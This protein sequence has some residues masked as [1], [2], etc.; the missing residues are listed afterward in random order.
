VAAVLQIVHQ[1]IHPNI[2]LDDPN[3]EILRQIDPDC[4]PVKAVERELRT[5]VKANFGF[6]D[7][8]ACLIFSKYN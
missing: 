4:L 3:P 1:F 6:G 5:V 8:N 2:N 7:V